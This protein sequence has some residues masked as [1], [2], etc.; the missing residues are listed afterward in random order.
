MIGC[1]MKRDGFCTRLSL[2]YGSQVLIDYGK[3]AWNE[4]LSRISKASNK[5]VNLL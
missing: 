4:N 5:E 2:L 3:L 1:L